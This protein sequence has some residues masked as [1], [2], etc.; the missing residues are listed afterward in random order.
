M[1]R[2]L[3]SGDARRLPVRA[4]GPPVQP[5]FHVANAERLEGRTL[6]SVFT[7]TTTADS[8]PG[9]LRQ[10]IL[11]ADAATSADEV[12]F[13]IPGTG[14]HTIRPLSPLPAD[15][16]GVA[17]DGTT[18][19]GYVGSPIIELDGSS[20]G[21]EADGLV[22]GMG[23]RVQGLVINRFGRHG[24]SITPGSGLA[25]RIVRNFIGTDSAG[26]SALGNEGDGVEC[27]VPAG[28]TSSAMFV[29]ENVISGNGR[30]GVRAANV[31]L[32]MGGNYVGLNATGTS[33][34]GNALDGVHV[35]G[36]NATI[37]P[38]RRRPS[39]IGRNV[40]SGNGG[41]GVHVINGSASIRD[42]FIGTDA[43]G[44]TA[45]GNARHGILLENSAGGVGGGA[46]GTWGEPLGN[47]ISGNRGHGI[48]LMGAPVASA[49]ARGPTQIVANRI[50]TN[51]T[52]DPINTTLGNGGHGVA[53]VNVPEATVGGVVDT[54]PNTIAFNAGSGVFVS[55]P[56]PT[57]S[58]PAT[59][60]QILRNSI[61]ANGRLGIDIAADGDPATGVTQNDPHDA[62]R[63]T[64]GL[65][66]YPVIL[67]A[68]PRP[69]GGTTVRFVLDTPINGK[70]RVEFFVSP[71]ADPT[72]FGEGRTYLGFIELGPQPTSP[73]FATADV[74]AAPTGSFVTATTTETSGRYTSEFSA[75]VPVT[76]YQPAS[77]VGRFLLAR[78]SSSPLLSKQPLMPGETGSFANV[79][80]DDV[81]ITAV[82]VDI[83]GVARPEALTAADFEFRAGTTPAVWTVPVPEQ[84]IVRPTDGLPGSDR[85]RVTALFRDNAIRNRWLRVTVKANER[86]G[87]AR[88]DV[89]YFGSLVGE[90]G[91]AGSPLR[92]TALD[93]AAVRRAMGTARVPPDS[94]LDFVRDRVI[95]AL[96]LAAVRRNL[97]GRLL[98]VTAPL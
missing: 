83:A 67:A 75:A 81:G 49:T 68:Q 25:A 62:D 16:G 48:L 28:V 31:W 97:R 3:L 12:R 70:Y 73:L 98:P 4:A 17:I 46:T 92:V 36:G 89:F 93:L 86:T 6:L 15:T 18:Q 61:F 20:A 11:D 35:I 7:V 85:V 84:I 43:G 30:Y 60:V 37:G 79:V 40:I 55:G 87:L 76:E 41:H 9:S 52:G 88:P 66:N 51:A 42:N 32:S 26:D 71:A 63:G 47:L 13:A 54:A 45:L 29:S 72:G 59:L 95:D 14:V 2:V 38:E 57:A 65:L 90:T 21:E 8:G 82:A 22:I 10:A 19:T 34:L 64:N 39:G 78:G 23:S 74:A 56:N 33:P 50:G 80:T 91:D 58:K 44:N 1:N 77:V 53:F 24:I 94:P 96:D 5:R 27:T 69:A